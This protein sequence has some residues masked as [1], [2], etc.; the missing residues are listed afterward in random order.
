MWSQRVRHD[1][2]TFTFFHFH[3]KEVEINELQLQKNNIN[4][5]Q[6]YNVDPKKHVAEEF[7]KNDSFYINEKTY[8]IVKQFLGPKPRW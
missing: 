2:A 5:T 6:K 7:I 4:E 3:H 1:W 8:K